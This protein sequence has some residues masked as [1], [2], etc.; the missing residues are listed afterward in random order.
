ML[1]DFSCDSNSDFTPVSTTMTQQMHTQR[2]MLLR[3]TDENSRGRVSRRL[4]DTGGLRASRWR[5]VH[6]YVIER[7]PIVLVQLFCLV[8]AIVKLLFRWWWWWWWRFW[9]ALHRSCCG[10]RK[11]WVLIIVTHTQSPKFQSEKEKRE[12]GE[13]KQRRGH[14][15]YKSQRHNNSLCWIKLVIFVDR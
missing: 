9:F 10:Q 4:L 3:I 2:S 15:N 11:V 5:H 7:H 12:M 8:L 14:C 6:F 13:L 1:Q